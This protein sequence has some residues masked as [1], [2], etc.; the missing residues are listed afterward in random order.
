MA[1]EGLYSAY[2]ARLDA[3]QNAGID[4]VLAAAITEIRPVLQF[5]ILV[6]V[7]AGGFAVWFVMQMPALPVG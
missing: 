6:S 1:A 5:A 4:V 3:A 2:A 7:V